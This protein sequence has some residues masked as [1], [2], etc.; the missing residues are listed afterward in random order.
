ML[1]GL[2]L[3]FFSNLP[4]ELLGLRIDYIFLIIATVLSIYSGIE[5]F[6][7]NK[8]LLLKNKQLNLAIFICKFLK[9]KTFVRKND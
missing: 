2:S 9:F 4:F 5:Y 7:Q 3:V 1:V 8:K 6:I